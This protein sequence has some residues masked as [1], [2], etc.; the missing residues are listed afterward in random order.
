MRKRI[1]QTAFSPPLISTYVLTQSKRATGVLPITRLS[2]P[3]IAARSTTYRGLLVA[4]LSLTSMKAVA[5]EVASMNKITPNIM[6]VK[7]KT[8]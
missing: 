1:S 5:Q 7:L 3:R 6:K 4:P 2:H 8:Y